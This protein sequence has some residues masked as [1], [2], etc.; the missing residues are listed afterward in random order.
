M[1]SYVMGKLR[2]QCSVKTLELPVV[3]MGIAKSKQHV[4]G[5]GAY[6]VLQA[7]IKR[8]YVFPNMYF[9]FGAGSVW[10]S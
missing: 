4:L 5:K 6:H 1:F 7:N 8:I 9:S 2:C 3:F 10:P